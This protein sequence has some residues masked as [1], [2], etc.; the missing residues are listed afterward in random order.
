[1]WRLHTRGKIGNFFDEGYSLNRYSKA[2][3]ALYT[4]G[5]SLQL[6]CITLS[7]K[8]KYLTPF[9]FSEADFF[10]IFHLN[11]KKDRQRVEEFVPG[12]LERRLPDFH[13][14]WYDVGVD[15]V[16]EFSPVPARE[17][18]LNSFDAKLRQLK[19]VI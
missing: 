16:S 11:D 17:T 3:E 15:K 9:T 12:D 8:P 6:P 5:R 10:Q 4:Q 1:M 13:S 2:L 18:I 14:L 7:Q 19:R